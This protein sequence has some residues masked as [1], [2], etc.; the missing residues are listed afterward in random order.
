MIEY[1]KKHPRCKYCKYL[2]KEESIEWIFDGVAAMDRYKIIKYYCPIK[3]TYIKIN[4]FRG[5]FC[6]IFKP[7]EDGIDI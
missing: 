6:K 5:Y 2:K 3:K 1:R 7:R 4:A